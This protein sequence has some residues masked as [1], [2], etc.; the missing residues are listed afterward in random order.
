VSTSAIIFRNSYSSMVSRHASSSALLIIFTKSS[1]FASTFSYSFRFCTNI[2]KSDASS[3]GFLVSPPFCFRVSLQFI[4]NSFSTFPDSEK[5]E[6][7]F[8]RTPI[9]YIFLHESWF[10]SL[11]IFTNLYCSLRI[12]ASFLQQ[13]IKA[14]A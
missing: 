11:P 3:F 12:K 7:C 5:F 10:F 13:C 8:L 14:K 2:S 4:S 9:K 6:N 1:T